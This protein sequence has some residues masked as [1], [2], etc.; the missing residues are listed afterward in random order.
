[1]ILVKCEMERVMETRAHK[2]LDV[3]KR[4]MELA[5]LIYGL[6]RVS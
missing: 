2:N 4:S 5:K 3:W 6:L 1:M